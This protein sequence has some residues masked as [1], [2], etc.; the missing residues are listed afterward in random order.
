MAWARVGVIGDVH[1]HADRL[2]LALA[3]FEERSVDAVVCLGDLVD[4]PG[5]LD[6][7]VRLLKDSGA[8]T[9]AGNHERWALHGEMRDLPNATLALS[10]PSRAWIADLPRTRRVDTT[11]GGALLC[12]GVGDDD[13]FFLNED[14]R[15]YA[16]Q[17]ILPELQPLML[18]PSLAFMIC[19]HTHQRMT[20]MFPGL[21]VVNAGTLHDDGPP[22]FVILD[23]SNLVMETFDI[24]PFVIAEAPGSTP[25]KPAASEPPRLAREDTIPLS[26]PSPPR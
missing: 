21:S 1:T 20:R 18:D 12:H 24:Q 13:F 17:G 2:A 7:C 9:I 25:T 6:A 11:A 14:T 19:A 10:E 5:D 4:G 3:T 26:L 15:G 23:F 22:G 8:V 16:L